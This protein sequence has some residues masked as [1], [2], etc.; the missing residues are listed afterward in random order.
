MTTNAEGAKAFYGD[1]FGWESRDGEMPG[2]VYKSGDAVGAMFQQ[3]EHPPHWNSYVSV[4]SADET[5]ARARVLGARIIEE[6]FEVGGFG[7][8]A[9]FTDSAGAMLCV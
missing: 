6:P 4:T 7:R 3:D 5:V 9:V 1:L 2:G 8:L